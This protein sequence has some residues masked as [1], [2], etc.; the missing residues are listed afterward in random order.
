M[1]GRCRDEG[2]VSVELAVLMPLFLVLVALAVVVGR[3]AVAQSAVELA[4]HDAARAA[5]LSRTQAA[6]EER[7]VDA[8][9][10]TLARQGL[11]CIELTVTVDVKGFGVPVGQPASVGVRVVCEVSFADVAMPGVPGTRTLNASFTSPLDRYRSRG[12]A[13]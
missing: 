5:S 8:A 12:G 6:A 2:S 9:T 13:V 3:Q 1:T 10:Q 11:G 4:A 7:A